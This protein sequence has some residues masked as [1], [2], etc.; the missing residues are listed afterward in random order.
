MRRLMPTL[1]SLLLNHGQAAA[2][3]AG[4]AAI[5]LMAMAF[6]P[7]AV[8]ATTQAAQPVAADAV[9]TALP[10]RAVAE[11]A[12]APTRL[13]RFIE[14]VANHTINSRFGLRHLVGERRARAHQG[15]DIAAPTGTPVRATADG[16]VVSSG[17]DAGG[18]GNFIEVRH[19]NGV[20]SFY[21]HLSRIEARAGQAVSAGQ[22]IGRVGSTGYSTGPHLHFEIRR[23][24]TR[25]N[26]TRYIG[27]EFSVR[28]KV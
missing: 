12:G 21:G 1:R 5:G 15:I 10:V 17:Y 13:L 19:A 26:P 14:P 3:A 6:A 27:R 23:A 2:H 16:V 7:Q 11:P 18:Y 20:R 22:R 28:M 8:I 25:L 24:G 9:P 4:L